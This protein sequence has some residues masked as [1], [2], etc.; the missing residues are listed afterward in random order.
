MTLVIRNVQVRY[1]GAREYSL[2]E[3]HIQGCTYAAG[4]IGLVFL[5]NMQYIRSL[6]YAEYKHSAMSVNVARHLYRS[7]GS[8]LVLDI[9]WAHIWYQ[10]CQRTP[11]FDIERAVAQQGSE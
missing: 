3:G 8:Q 6:R 11:L 5:G 10:Y 7:A 1:Y 9:T 2:I 4:E